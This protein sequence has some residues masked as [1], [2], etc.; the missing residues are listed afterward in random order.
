MATSNAVGEGNGPVVVNGVAKG[1]LV[2][3][4]PLVS[5]G[6]VAVGD[7]DGVLPGVALGLSTGVSRGLSSGNG[8]FIG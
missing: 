4:G 5:F 8:T 2:G 7:E 3:I 1:I 6:N